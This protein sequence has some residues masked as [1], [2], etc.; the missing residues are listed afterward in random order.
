RTDVD[1]VGDPATQQGVRFNMFHLLQS[2][3]RDGRTNIAAKGL[4]GE[5]YEGHYF[6]DTETYII[7]FFLYNNP[8]ISR[9][10]LE[11]RY[12]I[13][14]KARNRARQM[15]HP[16]GALFPWRTINGD[17]C[18]AYFPAGTAQYHIDADVAFAIK[19]YHEATGDD[20]FL[21]E[22]GAEILFETARLWVS[23]GAYIEGKGKAFCIN[24]V[25]GPDE[26]SA[27]VDNNC[28]TNLMARENLNYACHIAAWMQ[29]AAPEAYRQLVKRIGLEE[30]EI[31]E[32][33][34]AADAMYIP[35]DENLH[36]YKQDDNFLN[37]A[38]WDFANTPPENY[39][40]LIH[41]HP[42]VIYRHQVCK[43]ADFVL[44]LYLLSHKFTLDEK[45]RNYDYY[46]KVT[47]H[48]SSLSTCIFSIVGSEIGYH[49]K[50]YQYFVG[51]A[52]MDLDDFHGNVK[53]GIHAAN[54]AG[55]WLSLVNG[56]A[57]MRAHDDVLG[58]NPY[59]P[60]GWQSYSFKVT[61]R[62]CLL[63][64]SINKD[65]AIYELL[66]GEALTLQHKDQPLTL[67]KAEPRQSGA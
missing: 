50:A 15:S 44:A 16:K 13:L 56:F 35:Y 25:T 36:I 1:I 46:E 54:M 28:Y 59:L 39:P 64:V 42:L 48:D 11:Y 2:A 57:G 22:Y 55:T 61:Y 17:E 63:K 21:I 3:G 9:S 43:Q 38:A 14:D 12:R 5:G 40:L 52:R 41:Y 20:A 7:P 6:W 10:L 53:D 58:F 30:H 60:G 32:W 27:L 65:G 26:Y 29:K 23:L 51:T 34:R 18:S 37:K 45:K 24:C 31:A 33:Q 66:H 49:D 47:T 4:T 62:G 8:N 67:S 19:R